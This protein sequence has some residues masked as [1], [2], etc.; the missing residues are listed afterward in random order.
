MLNFPTV[1]DGSAVF[2]KLLFQGWLKSVF[3]EVR[4]LRRER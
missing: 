2:L 1:R 3:S 4:E